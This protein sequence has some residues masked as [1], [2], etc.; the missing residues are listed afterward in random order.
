MIKQQLL[1]GL[2]VLLLTGCS[3]KYGIAYLSNAGGNFDIYRMDEAG[4]E[5]QRLTNNPG[6]DWYPKWNEA[7]GLMV[8]YSNDTARNFSI[9]AMDR[10]GQAQ[11]LDT[12]GL[13]EYILSPDGTKVLFTQK[14]EDSSRIKLLEVGQA[15]PR[16]V[17]DQPGYNG[18]P[19]WAPG[20][21]AF[22]FIS[23]RSGTNELYRFDLATRQVTRLTNNNLREKY[24]SWLPDGKGIVYTASDDPNGERNDVYRIDTRSKEIVRITRDTFLYQEICVSPDGKRIAFHGTELGKDHIYTMKIDGTDKRQFTTG[25]AYHGEPE[26]IPVKR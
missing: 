4:T 20:S 6:W 21:K 15:E 25:A 19:K 5:P 17:V 12:Y 16:V 26:W 7:R 24:T 23:D 1:F 22:S 9:L 3:G 14:E 2:L 13:E 18:R 8:Y 10:E 11:P